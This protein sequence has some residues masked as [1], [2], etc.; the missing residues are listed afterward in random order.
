MR[1]RISRM[2]EMRGVDVGDDV[3]HRGKTQKGSIG[4]VGFGHQ[5]TPLSQAGIGVE[6]FEA[7]ADE[8]G[9]IESGFG[10]DPG[11]QAGG[12]GFAVAAGDGDA[13]F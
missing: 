11:D 12:G 7:P 5:K 6:T 1:G 10:E 8:A 9:G 3:H 2:I 13:F 4:F